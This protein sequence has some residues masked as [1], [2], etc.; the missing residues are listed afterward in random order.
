MYHFSAPRTSRNPSELLSLPLLPLELVM[1]FPCVSDGDIGPG[2]AA[3]P[4]ERD[5]G[6]VECVRGECSDVRAVVVAPEGLVDVVIVRGCEGDEV[7]A[8]CDEDEGGDVGLPCW[9]TECALNAAR[10]F[11]KNG[12]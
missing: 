2:D 1:Y 10:K 7:S 6:E 12:R 4:G 3:G 8:C 5:R 9:I 11:A